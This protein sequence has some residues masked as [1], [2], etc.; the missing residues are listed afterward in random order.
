MNKQK[1][2]WVPFLV[3]LV[4]GIGGM[5]GEGILAAPNITLEQ[6]VHFLSPDGEDVQV[7]PGQYEVEVAETWLKLVP[8]EGRDAWLI[9]ASTI[10]HDEDLINPVALSVPGKQADQHHVLLMLP[11]GKGL[12]AVGSYSGVRSRSGSQS[13]LSQIRQQHTLATQRQNLKP[14]DS[15]PCVP[16]VQKAFRAIRTHGDKLDVTHSTSLFLNHFRMFFR[17]VTI[18]PH[19]AVI[20]SIIHS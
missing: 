4:I 14:I 2:K 20:C 12:K 10:V 5:I 11:G 9:E 17:S 3:L 19:T 18:I 16:N 7:S 15:N 8:E 1:L 13:L 6:E